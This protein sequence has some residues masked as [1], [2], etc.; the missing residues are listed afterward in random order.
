MLLQMMLFNCQMSS[1]RLL[2]VP[3]NAGPYGTDTC[4]QSIMPAATK[5]APL[6][7]NFSASAAEVDKK[8]GELTL[9]VHRAL[10]ES[11]RAPMTLA[12]SMRNINGL[13]EA[14]VIKSLVSQASK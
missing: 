14:E 1:N 13:P 5:L 10:L 6:G 7:T 9:K 4:L 11:Y 2:V 3:K 12:T 8:D